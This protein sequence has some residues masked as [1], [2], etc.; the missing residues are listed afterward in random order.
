MAQQEREKIRIRT[1]AGQARARARGKI[2]GRP[3]IAVDL[4]NLVALRSEGLSW[5]QITART[6]ISK[7]TAQRNLASLPKSVSKGADENLSESTGEIG[8]PVCP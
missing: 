1:R 5:K 7:G 3:K 6:G 2:I 4:S 8:I